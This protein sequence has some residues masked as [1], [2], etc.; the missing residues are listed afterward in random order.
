MDDLSLAQQSRGSRTLDTI[1][2][3]Q[4]TKVI[5]E[6]PGAA[7]IRGEPEKL[8]KVRK[9]RE[10]PKPEQAEQLRMF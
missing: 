6:S 2:A 10:A 1:L 7:A 4:S 5:R 3:Q 8:K 9:P